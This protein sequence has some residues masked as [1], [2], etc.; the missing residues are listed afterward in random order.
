[1]SRSRRKTSIIGICGSASASEKKDKRFANKRLRRLQNI[2][3][4]KGLDVLPDILDVSNQYMM[5]KDGKI[6]FDP[7][8]YPKLMRK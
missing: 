5:S 1:M 6:Y 8:K 3:I 2:A 4:H 7:K